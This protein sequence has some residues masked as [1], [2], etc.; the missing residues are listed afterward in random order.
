VR[1]H[2]TRLGVDVAVAPVP[3]I[4]PIAAALREALENVPRWS[5]STAAA[6]PLF[7]AAAALWAAAPWDCLGGEDP[8]ALIE[9]GGRRLYASARPFEEDESAFVA[10]YSSHVDYEFAIEREVIDPD[11]DS[12]EETNALFVDTGALWVS[13][14]PGEEMP[15]CSRIQKLTT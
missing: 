11:F 10:F 14:L 15:V 12:D 2:L 4:D 1:P 13:F 5:M 3:Q 6:L 9:F 7:Q 8:S